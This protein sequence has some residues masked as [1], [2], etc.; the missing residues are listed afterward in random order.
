M[1]KRERR[2]GGGRWSKLSRLIRGLGMERGD[3]RAVGLRDGWFAANVYAAGESCLRS[4]GW[5]PEGLARL[6]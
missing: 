6:A 3:E 4:G 2:D 1:A 5:C